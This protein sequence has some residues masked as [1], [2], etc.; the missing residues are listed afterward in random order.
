LRGIFRAGKVTEF[1]YGQIV[2][3]F[4]YLAVFVAPPAGGIALAEFI[5]EFRQAKRLAAVVI[6]QLAIVV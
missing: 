3:L 2:G 6:E 5:Y 4:E 1:A